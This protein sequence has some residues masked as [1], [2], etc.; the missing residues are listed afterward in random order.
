MIPAGTVAEDLRTELVELANAQFASPQ[1][2]KLMAVPLSLE[3]GRYWEIQ[4]ALWSLNRRDC[5]PLVQSKAP[6]PVKRLI[7]EHEEEELVGDRLAGKLDHFALAIREGAELGLTA[8]D[9]ANAELSEGARVCGYAWVHLAQSRSWLEGLAA[10][11]ILEVRNS[12]EL[13]RGGSMAH[14]RSQKWAAEL[15]IPVHKQVNNVE[16]AT[17][18]VAHG[19]LL[20]DV[21]RDYVRTAEDRQAVI[22]GAADSLAIERVFWGHLA[23]GMLALP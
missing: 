3:R 5:W 19:Q 13:M 20:F 21:A 11:A 8:E 7:W 10:S 6:L 9:F 18:D 4:L 17:I 16:H 22:R 12:N 14:R 23:D 2:H 15:G 1:Y